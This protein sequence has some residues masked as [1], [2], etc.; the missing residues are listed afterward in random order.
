MVTRRLDEGSRMSYNQEEGCYEKYLLLKQG[1]YSYQYLTVDNS[2]S[3][4]E[5]LEGD[6]YPTRNSYLVAVYHRNRLDRYDRLIGFTM[7]SL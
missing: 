5:A 6:H 4:T 3:K 7:L 2:Q 1:A